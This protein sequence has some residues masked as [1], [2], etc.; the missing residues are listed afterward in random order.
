MWFRWVGNGRQMAASRVG[1]VSEHCLDPIIEEIFHGAD[2]VI[3]AE[4]QFGQG[5]PVDGNSYLWLSIIPRPGTAVPH[6]IG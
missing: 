5:V 6:Q 2:I 3:G 1:L 4:R